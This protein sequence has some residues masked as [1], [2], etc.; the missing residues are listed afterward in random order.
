MHFGC[1]S[2]RCDTKMRCQNCGGYQFNSDGKCLNC[3]WTE[4]TKPRSG[5]GSVDIFKLA[6][7]LKK[8][9]ADKKP[10]D[11]R[12]EEIPR[13]PECPYCHKFSLFFNKQDNIFE[14]INTKCTMFNKPIPK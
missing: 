8:R 10:E 2:K 9:E 4:P 14:C 7:E 6:E 3:G 1:P 5:L 12:R 11:K 13:L